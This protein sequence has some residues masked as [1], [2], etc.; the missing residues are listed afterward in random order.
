MGYEIK[1]NST[2]LSRKDLEDKQQ[3][4]YQ[5]MYNELGDSRRKIFDEILE[6]N[7]V[8]EDYK[9]LF[10]EKELSVLEMDNSLIKNDF[11]KSIIILISL[12]KEETME[13]INNSLLK[14]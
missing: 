6:E 9:Y 7:L 10:S 5:K 14:R 8:K 13:K 1:S 2:L 3:K 11:A 12:Y 4:I